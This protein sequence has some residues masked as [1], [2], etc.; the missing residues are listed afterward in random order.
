MLDQMNLAGI[1][2]VTSSPA[3]ESG[4]THSGDPDGATTVRSGPDHA[5]ANLSAA[6]AKE[7]GLMTS[8][9]YGQPSIGLSSSAA[10]SE[11]LGNRLQAKQARLGSTLY[12]Q[13]WKVKAM[14]SGRLLLRL[15]VSAHRIKESDSIGALKAW[16]TPQVMDIREAHQKSDKAKKGGCSNLR[17]KAQLAGWR[18]PTED[19]SSNVTPNPKRRDGLYSLVHLASWPTPT[20]RDHKDGS[21]D[22]SVPANSLL[23]RAVW[24]A[25]GAA[26]LTACGELLTGSSA[27]ME[28]GGQLNPAH[29]RWLMGLPSEWDDCAVTA[30]QSLPRK[31]KRSSKAT[32]R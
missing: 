17:E 6:Q 13:T 24:D 2:S 10:L 11:S 16:P 31:R 15:V 19:D 29:S 9:T 20:K 28:S 12:R 18:T 32:S 7:K 14:P 8:G 21:S 27:E 30:M 4:V 5:H 22:G 1:I 23:G 3:S 25:K 26:R